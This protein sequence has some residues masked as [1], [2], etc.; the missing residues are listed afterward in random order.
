MLD[1]APDVAQIFIWLTRLGLWLIF[2][3]S[4]AAPNLDKTQTL[5][6]ERYGPQAAA[7]IDGWKRLIAESR[8]LEE[9]EQLKRVN[10]FFNRQMLFRSDK[11][12][13]QQED[14]WATPLEFVGRGAG[15][16]EDF[17]IAK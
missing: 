10:L 4:V 9:I 1:C 11:D 12:I 17:T 3:I 13:W 8:D 16:C 2:A 7:V 15:D 5:A 6:L 14:Y